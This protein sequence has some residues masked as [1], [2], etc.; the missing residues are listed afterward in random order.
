MVGKAY[1]QY[2]RDLLGRY[3][4]SSE[5]MSYSNFIYQHSAGEAVLAMSGDLVTI[6]QVLLSLPTRSVYRHISIFDN[7]EV[8]NIQAFNFKNYALGVLFEF[9]QKVGYDINRDYILEQAREDC[10]VIQSYPKG[11]QVGKTHV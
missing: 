1:G 6:S 5:V 7:D 2:T 3:Y 4:S 9:H 11:Y 8:W 10:L